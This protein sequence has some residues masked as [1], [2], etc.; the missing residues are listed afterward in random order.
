MI[1]FYDVKLRK[2]VMLEP[3]MVERV[4]YERVTKDG[5][6]QVR[7]ALRGKTPDGRNLTKF[8]SKPDYDAHK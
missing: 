8:V 5:K 1:K 2:A 4:T 3:A 6:K 7:Y